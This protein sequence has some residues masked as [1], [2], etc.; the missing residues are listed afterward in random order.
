MFTLMAQPP[1]ARRQR[2][3]MSCR[4]YTPSAARKVAAAA[5]QRTEGDGIEIAEYILCARCALR[6]ASAFTFYARIGVDEISLRLAARDVSGR[7]YRF[8]ALPSCLS[9]FLI[10][11]VI[12]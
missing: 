2:Y 9:K 7:R 8:A 10:F 3:P 11:A 5:C 4:Y 12:I 1:P 6:H